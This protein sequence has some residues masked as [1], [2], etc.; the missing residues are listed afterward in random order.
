MV[1]IMAEEESERGRSGKVYGRVTNMPRLI[2]VQVF[3][4]QDIKKFITE[5]IESCEFKAIS[6]LARRVSRQ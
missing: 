3:R 6:E 5:G 4:R 1:I 2:S